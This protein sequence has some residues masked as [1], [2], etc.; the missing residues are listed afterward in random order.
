[1]NKDDI[2]CAHSVILVRHRVCKLG[3]LKIV[4]E[5]Q[6]KVPNNARLF[7]RSASASWVVT[8]RLRAPTIHHDHRGSAYHFCVFL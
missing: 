3:R 2:T 1:M 6:S 7:R 5:K 4:T 8:P